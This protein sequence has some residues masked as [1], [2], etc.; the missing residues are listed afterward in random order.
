MVEN[1]ITDDNIERIEMIQRRTEREHGNNLGYI[2]KK[3]FL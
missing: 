2:Y 3:S 1:A